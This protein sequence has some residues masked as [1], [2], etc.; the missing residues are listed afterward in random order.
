MTVKKETVD[1]GRKQKMK[2]NGN[3]RVT[4]GVVK[5]GKGTLAST[6][7]TEMHASQETSRRS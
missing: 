7:H 5:V 6:V 4:S 1:T 2:D 3:K